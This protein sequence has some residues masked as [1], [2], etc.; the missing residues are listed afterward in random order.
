[1]QP[2][3]V[4]V[5]VE[6]WPQSTWNRDLQITRRAAE[7]TLRLLDL[8]AE[9]H[10][11]VT[12]FVLGKFAEVF[13]DVV[14]R[15]RDHGH[16]VASHG[17]GHVEIF[18]QGRD[19]FARDVRRARDLLEDIL[20]VRVKGYRAPDFS[21]VRS[22]LWALEVL[23]ESGIEYDSSIFPVRHPR[24][25][26][27]DWPAHPCRLM[28]ANGTSIIELPIA[29][30]RL[31]ARNWP[32]GGGGYHRLL[33]GFAFRALARRIIGTR[34]FVFYCHPYERDALEFAQMEI[35]VPLRVRLHQGLGRARFEARFRA[36]LRTFGTQTMDDFLLQRAGTLPVKTDALG[37]AE[38]SVRA[39]D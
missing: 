36:F 20:G 12:M 24:Y 17:Y 25:G 16:E 15:I 38:Q 8:L 1:V 37:Q 14:R 28:L 4:T 9:E 7:N 23:A 33:P 39:Q 31:L 13:P 19:E 2:A 18:R 30:F 35:P 6:D 29:T 3:L 34:P 22:T 27:D 5:D 11:R 21:I 10:A 26:I 32:V